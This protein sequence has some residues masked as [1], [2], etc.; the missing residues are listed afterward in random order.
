MK[1]RF[2]LVLCFQ[3]ISGLTNCLEYD[4]VIQKLEIENLNQNRIDVDEKSSPQAKIVGGVH[5]AKGRYPYQVGLMDGARDV[6]FCGAVL[7]DP[8]WVLSAAHCSGYSVSVEI[9]RYDFAKPEDFSEQ[10]EVKREILHPGYNTDTFDND[11]ML[12]ELANSSTITPV[13]LDLTG[14]VLKE[15]E[16]GDDMTVVGWGKTKE[17]FFGFQS[18][19]LLETDVGFVPNDLCNS[20]YDGAITDNMM[21]GYRKGQDSCQGD[22]GGPLLIK[23][24]ESSED[25]QVG[26][27]SFG[28]GC[29]RR[30][31]FPGVY[32]T[33]SE[34]S[35][36]IC[37]YV[38]LDG[39]SKESEVQYARE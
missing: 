36:F 16:L 1:T 28:V 21:C 18:E 26:V 31:F 6:P 19:V 3:A 33:L 13:K 34:A 24:S 38:D 37:Q 23:G 11:V 39:C 27:V 2:T 5:S 35:D 30:R 10:I 17:G 15:L 29:A 25:V 12:I 22:S 7:I 4:S 32:A 8:T 9:G 20:A 14:S